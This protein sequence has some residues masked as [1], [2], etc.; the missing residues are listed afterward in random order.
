MELDELN[1]HD[2]VYLQVSLL[3]ASFLV[4]HVDEV[5]IPVGHLFLLLVV[6]VELGDVFLADFSERT[7]VSAYEVFYLPHVEQIFRDAF[8]SELLGDEHLLV[9]WEIGR[10]VVWGL[11]P[12]SRC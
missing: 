7:S 2:L 4:Y 11:T 3:A 6:E 10:L 1:E 9:V 8:L 5:A 12:I